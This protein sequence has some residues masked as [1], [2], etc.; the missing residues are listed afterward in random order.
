MRSPLQGQSGPPC[1]LNAAHLCTETPSHIRQAQTHTHTHTHT[2]SL[3]HF[4]HADT[5][6]HMQPVLAGFEARGF[7]WGAPLALALHCAFV[8][9]RKPGKLPGACRGHA[10][11]LP[12]LLACISDGLHPLHHPWNASPSHRQVTD[13]CTPVLRRCHRFHG[14]DYPLRRILNGLHRHGA[15]CMC[16]VCSS[17]DPLWSAEAGRHCP[18]A[19][20]L[21]RAR[22][23]MRHARWGCVMGQ[24]L[25]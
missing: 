12:V 8:P 6:T 24:R 22:H 7:I 13:A 21:R 20:V 3:T 17:S 4:T 16:S 11:S 1:L 25:C 9:L 19:S 18:G 5:L 2:H 15:A 14:Q 10:T 23:H